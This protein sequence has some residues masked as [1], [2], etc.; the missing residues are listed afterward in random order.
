MYEAAQARGATWLDEYAQNR[1]PGAPKPLLP[2]P[3]ALAP[4]APFQPDML[5]DA[6][7]AYVMDV[8]DR[9]QCP[10]DFVAVT[11]ICALSALVAYSALS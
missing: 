9:Q 3:S 6:I 10:P 1:Q 5:P 11:A 2:L 7:S 4:V 8:A